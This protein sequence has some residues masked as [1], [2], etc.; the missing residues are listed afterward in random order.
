MKKKTKRALGIGAAS[1]AAFAAGIIISA[2]PAYAE[3]NSS[4]E[5][6]TAQNIA[7]AAQE[8]EPVSERSA[9]DAVKEEKEAEEKKDALKAVYDKDVADEEYSVKAQQDHAKVDEQA[10]V[11]EGQAETVAD[12]AQKAADGAIVS[13]TDESEMT[14]KEETSACLPEDAD[15][16]DEHDICINSEHDYEEED[17]T[18]PDAI[19]D[20]NEE[21]NETEEFENVSEIVNYADSEAAY[22]DYEHMEGFLDPYQVEDIIYTMGEID[23][24]DFVPVLEPE[25][26]EVKFGEEVEIKVKNKLDKP[27]PENSSREIFVV[28]EDG[29][30]DILYISPE[31]KFFFSASEGSYDFWVY[32]GNWGS[33]KVSKKSITVKKPK[34]KVVFSLEYDK[35]TV[36]PGD[37]ITITMKP[38]FSYISSYIEDGYIS[39]RSKSGEA[40]ALIGVYKDPHSDNF[41]GSIKIDNYW[42]NGQYIAIAKDFYGDYRD[43][44][45]FHH[46]TYYDGVFDIHARIQVLG[47]L[48]LQ[49]PQVGGGGAGIEL[50]SRFLYSWDEG[51]YSNRTAANEKKTV[52]SVNSMNKLKES[53]VVS[54]SSEKSLTRTKAAKTGD[55]N[56]IWSIISIFSAAGVM[57]LSAKSVR[58]YKKEGS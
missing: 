16:T 40:V 22:E 19:Y 2:T 24:N 25:K 39:V 34:E 5:V 30:T 51:N 9:E 41:V 43:K 15:T 12:E 48:E 45:G 56:N 1:V 4:C 14:G 21:K 6:A 27:L 35:K 58:F 38:D 11:A 36:R 47:S 44:E 29:N 54:E 17:A 50:S 53:A 46:V 37:V 28:E 23:E 31:S 42:M 52:S 49:R 13:D 26:T 18:E 10:N 57:I 8:K 33:K 55:E 32:D 3:E 7:E 20:P